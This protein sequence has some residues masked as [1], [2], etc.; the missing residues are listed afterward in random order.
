MKHTERLA[1]AHAAGTTQPA[2]RLAY[3]LT[4]SELIYASVRALLPCALAAL[5]VL[6]LYQ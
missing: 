2:H 4:S 3:R 1:T 5:L 6:V